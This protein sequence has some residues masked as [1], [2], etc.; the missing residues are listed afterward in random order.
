M[1]LKMNVAA[2]VILVF[3]S[4]NSSADDLSDI[5]KR[6]SDVGQSQ[7]YRGTFILRKSDNLSALEVA[8]GVDEKGVWER[9]DSLNG[10]T[11]KILRHNNRII[12][13][14]PERQLVTLRHTNKQQSLHLQLPENIDKLELFYSMT[15]LKDDRI[16]NHAALVV[17]LLPRDQYRYGYR[18]WIDKETGMLLRCDLISE[19]NEIIEQMMFTSLEYLEGASSHDFDL[20]QFERFNQQVMNTPETEVVNSKETKWQVKQLPNGFM[21]TQNT[22]RYLQ[23]PVMNKQQADKETAGMAPDLQHLVFSD[24]LASVSVFIEKNKG[25]AGHLQG[26]SS[27][28]AVNAYGYSSGDFFV[29]VVGEVP[30]KTVQQMAQTA[31]KMP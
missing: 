24:G 9:M 7:N 5:L 21:L 23:Q 8:H 6:M 2:L 29:T 25:N 14:Y 27:M 13:V 22:M 19:N 15:R 11:K 4:A 26:A 10:E 16:A 12:S 3:A 30:E 20:Q 17:D 28:G 31:I 1:F 18:Y